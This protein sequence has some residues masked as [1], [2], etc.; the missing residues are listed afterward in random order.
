MHKFKKKAHSLQNKQ[1]NLE[2][3]ELLAADSGSVSILTSLLNRA[4]LWNCTETHL[5]LDLDRALNS[6]LVD[7]FHQQFLLRLVARIV[8]C[9]IQS[10]QSFMIVWTKCAQED[11]CYNENT[12][13]GSL[14]KRNRS[15]MRSAGPERRTRKEKEPFCV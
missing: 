12:A 11:N 5:L 6:C 3:L 13:N 14:I 15:D 4:E 10:R 2:Q 8:P 1:E 7:C 9:C